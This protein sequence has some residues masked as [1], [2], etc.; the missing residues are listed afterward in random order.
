MLLRAPFVDMLSSRSSVH[1]RGSNVVASFRFA[2]VKYEPNKRR[3][4]RFAMRNERFR[5]A[6]RKALKSLGSVNH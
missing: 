3:E 6:D 5:M 2:Q 4:H 1:E